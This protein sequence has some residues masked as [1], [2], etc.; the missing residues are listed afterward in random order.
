MSAAGTLDQRSERI[1]HGALPLE[2]LRFGAPLALGMGLQT[3]FNLVDAYIIARLPSEVSGPALGA[4][5]ICDQLAA[6][7]TIVSYGI[8]VAAAS[9]VS[10][11]WGRGAGG[12]RYH[13]QRAVRRQRD[14]GV[15]PGQRDQD[16]N[17]DR[18]VSAR[19]QR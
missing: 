5:G 2:V 6:L 15:S 12:R 16:S 9:L 10:R 3:A 14:A 4:I 11:A 19:R 17:P 8:S 18:A 7:G 1:L 13:E